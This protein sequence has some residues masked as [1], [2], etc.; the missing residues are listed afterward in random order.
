MGENQETIH[1]AAKDGRPLFMVGD[2]MNFKV[3]GA[4]TDGAH[5]VWIDTIAPGGGPPPHVH[6]REHEDFYI[7]EGQFD[8]YREGQ[9]PVRGNA[10]D[11]IHTPKGVT[12]TYQ[13][14][15]TSVGRML[16]IAVPGGIERF[17]EEVGEPAGAATEPPALPGEP[18]PEQIEYLVQTAQ[19]YGIEIKL[20]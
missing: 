18:S 19:K 9:E 6:H 13:N 2:L 14:V 16:G 4:D 12:H 15:G 8:F 17:F 7:L 1:I 10:G 20:A 11:F 5:T 3:T